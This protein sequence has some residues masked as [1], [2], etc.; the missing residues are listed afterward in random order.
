ML[1]A[2]QSHVARW[3][4]LVCGEWV[5]QYNYHSRLRISGSLCILALSR[6]VSLAAFYIPLASIYGPEKNVQDGFAA[7][8]Q[9]VHPLLTFGL[10][11]LLLIGFSSPF[12]IACKFAAA[13]F[14]ISGS[15][16][17][18]STTFFKVE[19]RYVKGRKLQIPGAG[20]LTFDEWIDAGNAIYLGC[21]SQ[22]GDT[23]IWNPT[24]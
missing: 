6:R 5:W 18:H 22:S 4:H 21:R 14:A 23:E 1:D 13:I 3:G 9:V 8:L 20:E 15:M 19:Q 12:S 7:Y 16:T 24:F 17:D 11:A 10:P 2:A